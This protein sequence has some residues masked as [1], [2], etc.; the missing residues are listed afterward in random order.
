[1]SLPDERSGRYATP[2]M[3]GKGQCDRTARAEL[4]PQQQQPRAR[5]DSEDRMV[6]L[7]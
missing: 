4:A 6:P 7:W 5:A 2:T 1:M 3:R